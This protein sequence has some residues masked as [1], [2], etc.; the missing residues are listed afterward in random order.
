MV[1]RL[2]LVAVTSAMLGIATVANAQ[3]PTPGTVGSACSGAS[4][5]QLTISDATGSSS[6]AGTVTIGF[7]QA[8]DDAQAQRGADDVAALAFTVGIPGSGSDT[9]LVVDCTGGTLADGV[10]AVAPALANDF[11][12]VVENAQCTNRNRCLCPDTGAGQERDNFI[13]IALYGPKTL[14]EQ[15]PVTIPPLPDNGDIVILKLKANSGAT[16]TVPMHVF[17]ALDSSKPQFSANLSMG[18]QSACDVS[19]SGGSSTVAFD[20]GTFTISD[21]PPMGCAGD[22]NGD[23]EVTINELITGVNI[24]LGSQPVSACPAFDVS[25]TD[26]EV[27]INE[28]IAAVNNALGGCPS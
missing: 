17:S 16:G 24:A 4:C 11:T 8:A 13:N 1:Q 26:G 5:A 7:K 19:A 2:A 27:A 20:D 6:A 12:V 14:P 22:C 10:V 23:G 9:P 18:D 15:G 21:V 28:L 25:P 3:C